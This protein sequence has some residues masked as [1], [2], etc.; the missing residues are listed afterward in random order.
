MAK[1]YPNIQVSVIQSSDMQDVQELSFADM[2]K[3]NW[4]TLLYFYPK[5]NTSWCSIEAKDFSDNQKKFAKMGIQ[6]IGVSKDS[7]KSHCSFIQKK[8]LT[9]PLISDTELALHTHFDVR[10]EKSLYGRKYMGAERSTFLL[11]DKGKILQEWRNVKAVWH[12]KSVLE[13]INS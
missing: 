9:I 2:L 13:E 1:K 12:V 7:V 5:D 8:E 3:E 10:K 6:I 11:D 4:Q